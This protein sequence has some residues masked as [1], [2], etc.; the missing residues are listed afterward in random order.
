M[1]LMVADSSIAIK[2]L[3]WFG[4]VLSP[5]SYGFRSVQIDWAHNNN[6]IIIVFISIV[7]T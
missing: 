5:G 4:G 6:I 3:A 7:Q 2:F 1:A